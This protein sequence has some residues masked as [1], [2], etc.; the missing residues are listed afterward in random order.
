MR[1]APT[2]SEALFGL[3]PH[4]PL[5]GFCTIVP[6]PHP[7]VPGPKHVLGRRYV[8]GT[9][10]VAPA[11]AAGDE[12]GTRIVLRVLPPTPV[13]KRSRV[14]VRCRA[15]KRKVTMLVSSYQR[16][17]KCP[18]QRRYANRAADQAAE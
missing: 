9:S 5:R 11:V 17:S 7:F 6:D 14:L 16:G 12:D 3:F 13:L 1:D 15:C 8:G 2:G 18:C 4:I 10:Q